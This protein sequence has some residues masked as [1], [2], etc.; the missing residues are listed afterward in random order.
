[1]DF[2]TD[3]EI[4]AI[5]AIR[6]GQG[7]QRLLPLLDYKI[8]AINPKILVGFSDKTVLQLGLLKK[9]GLI[10]YT[11]FTLTVPRN[12]LVEKTLI[13]CLSGKSF[14]VQEGATVH[15]GFTEG[16]LVGGNL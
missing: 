11:G 7:S 14:H 6:G 16:P 13:A 9:T 10:T 1:M 12:D 5:I 15:S 3:K 2:F 8:I 4:K